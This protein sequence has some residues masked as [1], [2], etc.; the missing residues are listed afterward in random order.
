M[1]SPVTSPLENINTI[2]NPGVKLEDAVLRKIQN[3][4][5]TIIQGMHLKMVMCGMDKN[6]MMQLTVSEGGDNSNDFV[7][8]FV[9]RMG[10][11]IAEEIKKFPAINNS[12]NDTMPYFVNG[13]AIK[14][15]MNKG[16]MDILSK[17][18]GPENAYKK[19]VIYAQSLPL[20][21]QFVAAEGEENIRKI[22]L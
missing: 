21:K 10:L 1:I 16:N 3:L 7:K 15:E 12:L 5:Q 8:L 14:A 18:T 4:S 2:I 9:D 17:F 22:V 11:V 19:Q 20:L 6:K 13:D